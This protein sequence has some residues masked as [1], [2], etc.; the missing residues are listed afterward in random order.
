MLL[1]D[2]ASQCDYNTASYILKL[3]KGEVGRVDITAGKFSIDHSGGLDPM[4]ILELK[5][6]EKILLVFDFNQITP[7]GSAF[8]L[9]G[10]AVSA[11]ATANDSPVKNLH[12]PPRTYKNESNKHEKT[13][14]GIHRG[15]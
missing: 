3:T 6:C 8:G 14:E 12:N 15:G 7:S 1:P 4:K 13:G 9:L 5:P 2:E 10:I 11:I